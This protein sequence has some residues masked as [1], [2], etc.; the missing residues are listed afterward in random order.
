MVLA[1]LGNVPPFLDLMFILS[2][3]FRFCRVRI[4]YL[5]IFYIDILIIFIFNKFEYVDTLLYRQILVNFI[6][7]TYV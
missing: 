2:L 1:V 5:L 3:K 6:D 7:V 4:M